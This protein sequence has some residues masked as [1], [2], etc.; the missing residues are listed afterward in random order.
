MG[1]GVGLDDVPG[2]GQGN[3]PGT[4]VPGSPGLPRGSPFSDSFCLVATTAFHVTAKDRIQ[5]S[6]GPDML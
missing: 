1:T 3:E 5:L 6:W 4:A 2:L